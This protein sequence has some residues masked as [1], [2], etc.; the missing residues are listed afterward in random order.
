MGVSVTC[1]RKRSSSLCG[2]P[3]G[4][5][6]QGCRAEGEERDGLG[7]VR[8]PRLLILVDEEVGLWAVGPGTVDDTDRV[9]CT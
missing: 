8:H 1:H 2:L 4:E 7:G 6:S 9:V 5:S 3:W